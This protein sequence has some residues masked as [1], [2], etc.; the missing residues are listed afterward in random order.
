M[1]KASDCGIYPDTR[2]TLKVVQIAPFFIFPC[3]VVFRYTSVSKHQQIIKALH[4]CYCC[5]CWYQESGRLTTKIVSFFLL[6]LPFTQ[7]WLVGFPPTT[8]P[9][10]P[11]L[12]AAL[13]RVD[14]PLWELGLGLGL[15]GRTV[16]LAGRRGQSFHCTDSPPQSSRLLC[17]TVLGNRN[18]ARTCRRLPA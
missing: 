6:S 15:V 16:L 8:P 4:C 7:F 3:S 14:L 18:F 1:V 11:V 10:P 2:N 5:C 17:A 12:H 9:P 13:P